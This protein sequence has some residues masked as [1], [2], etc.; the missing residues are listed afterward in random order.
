MVPGEENQLVPKEVRGR[1]AGLGPKPADRSEARRP[2]AGGWQGRAP[3]SRLDG[4]RGGQ[5]ETAGSWGPCSWGRPQAE[6]DERNRR[7]DRWSP[8]P[9]RAGVGER[10]SGLL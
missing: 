1:L 8:V 3:C 2:G 9:L 5:L 10:E 4:G 6:R 7:L